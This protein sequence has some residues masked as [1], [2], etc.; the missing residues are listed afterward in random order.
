MRRLRRVFLATDDADL[1][2]FFGGGCS[3][4]KRA[5]CGGGDWFLNQEIRKAGMFVG[6]G[7]A[8]KWARCGGGDGCL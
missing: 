5:Q 4:R 2:G 1:R 8:W 6:G 7:G 3:A